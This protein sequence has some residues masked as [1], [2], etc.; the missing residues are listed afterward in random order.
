[1]AKIQLHAQEHAKEVEQAANSHV[2][3]ALADVE[4]QTTEVKLLAQ[5]S[6]WQTGGGCAQP[7]VTVAQAQRLQHSV[8]QV[9]MSALSYRKQVCV[10]M[11][12]VIHI[13]SERDTSFRG[14]MCWHSWR[15]VSSSWAICARPTARC[16]ACRPRPCEKSWPSAPPACVV[17]LVRD[18]ERL[19]IE[20]GKTE[21]Y[22]H[23]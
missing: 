21:Q 4:T 15:R 8:E 20:L 2:A 5:S 22:D 23:R 12:A 10:C 1:V 17:Q 18:M 13:S 9:Q 6:Y 7:V 19:R 3:Q 16:N 11:G 14:M